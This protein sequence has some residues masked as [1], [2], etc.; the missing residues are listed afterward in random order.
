[1]QQ[2][3]IADQLL[4]AGVEPVGGTPEQLAAALRKEA[5]RVTAAARG[6]GLRAE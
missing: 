2:P 4:Q 1:V 6:A 5:Q 3:G